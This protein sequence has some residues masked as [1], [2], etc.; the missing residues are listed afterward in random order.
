MLWFFIYQTTSPEDDDETSRAKNEFTRME[1]FIFVLLRYICKKYQ[2]G[3]GSKY[4][5]I[6]NICC[7]NS[8]KDVNNILS[9]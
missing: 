8:T 3:G 1:A 9:F 4:T 6:I 5:Q 7:L 2:R